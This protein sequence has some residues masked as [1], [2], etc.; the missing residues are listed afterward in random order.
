MDHSDR[1]NVEEALTLAQDLCNQANQCV[2]EKQNSDS[3][4][5]I[6]RHVHCD[7]MAENIVFNSSTNCLGQRRLIFNGILYKVEIFINIKAKTSSSG[8]NELK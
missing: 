5:W 2:K 6:Q 8:K 3:L 4:E 1:N 7:G